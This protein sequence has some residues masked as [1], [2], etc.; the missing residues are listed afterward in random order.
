MVNSISPDTNPYG[1]TID[2]VLSGIKR[3]DQGDIV[4]ATALPTTYLVRAEITVEDG[5]EKDPRAEDW[6]EI[7]LDNFEELSVQIEESSDYKVVW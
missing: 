3:N 2:R 5:E 1:Y 4:S 7:Y 6:E